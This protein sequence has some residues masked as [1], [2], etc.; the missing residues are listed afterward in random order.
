MSSSTTITELRTMQVSDLRKEIRTQR[1]EVQKMRI[2]I[3]M[4]TEKDTAKY[5]REK[6]QLA[7]MLTVLTEKEREATNGIKAIKETK[8]MLNVKPKTAKV[9]SPKKSRATSKT[10]S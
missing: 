7:R 4:N 8:E 6:R 10:S 9:S 5:R 2:Q 1:T 3:T